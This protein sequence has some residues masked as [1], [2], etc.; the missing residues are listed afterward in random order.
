MF[1]YEIPHVH[2]QWC[3]SSYTCSKD[4]HFFGTPNTVNLKLVPSNCVKKKDKLITLQD[5]KRML[6]G[7]IQIDCTFWSINDAEIEIDNDTL[8][9]GR[10][11]MVTCKKKNWVA[12]V[13]TADDWQAVYKANL[14]D[15]ETISLA[16]EPEVELDVRKYCMGLGVNI[17]NIDMSKVNKSLFNDAIQETSRR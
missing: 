4:I 3:V 10:E 9:M 17:D 16:Y 12:D 13:E 6:K 2:L 8:T 11:I 15:T 7:E 1:I 14:T 5:G